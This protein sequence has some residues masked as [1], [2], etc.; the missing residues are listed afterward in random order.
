VAFSRT[1]TLGVSE[2]YLLDLSEDLFPTKPPRQLSFSK[3]WKWGL[4]W[5]PDGR[6][7]IYSSGSATSPA[8]TML[9]RLSRSGSGE[10]R[11]VALAGEHGLWPAISRRRNRLAFSRGYSKDQNVWRLDL[12]G[13]H[14][15][16]GEAVAL[17]GSTRNDLVPQYSPDGHKI[18]FVSERSGHNEL[19]VCNQDGSGAV[20]LTSLGATFTGPPRWSPD[21][22]RIV[23]DSNATGAFHVYVVDAAG[24]RPKRLTDPPF[25]NGMASYSRDGRFVYFV[26]NRT[27]AWEIWRM[28]AAGGQATQVTAKGGY[29]AFESIDGRSLFYAK[30]A[31]ESSLWKMPVH[32]GE[33]RQVLDSVYGIGFVVRGDGIYFIRPP[34][35]GGSPTL[36]FLSFETGVI[37]TITS[38]PHLIN[39]GLSISPDGR[40]ALYTR[41]DEVHGGDLMVVEN[42]R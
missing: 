26:S 25:E 19:W 2:V 31:T 33:E 5:T 28:P 29:V 30:R 18:A 24:G 27:K 17:V 22:S 14:A 8:E 38:I 32:G 10:P 21:G 42:F 9:L 4:E 16:A 23:F 13:P 35:A 20:Q 36:R 12:S 7:I 6:E 1:L 39:Q 41:E 11:V 3:Q 37:K 34:E 40:Y 15:N